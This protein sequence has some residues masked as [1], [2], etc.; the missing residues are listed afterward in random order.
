MR[1]KS[2][3]GGDGAT[4][5][6]KASSKNA[7]TETT[8]IVSSSNGT[9]GDVNNSGGSSNNGGMNDLTPPVT[10]VENGNGNANDD[11]AITNN[12]I[13]PELKATKDNLK[14][15]I[16]RWEEHPNSPYVFD[17]HAHCIS[18]VFTE[19]NGSG[20]AGSQPDDA[21]MSSVPLCN[22]SSFLSSRGAFN[23]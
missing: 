10:C 2:S 4:T 17:T 12:T 23:N 16:E 11:E 9:A 8:A 3:T 19:R 18:P 21:E 15:F 22:G 6:T 7:S 14:S 5:T 20:V 13:N 1:R